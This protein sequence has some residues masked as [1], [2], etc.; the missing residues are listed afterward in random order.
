MVVSIKSDTPELNGKFILKLVDRRYAKQLRRTQRVPPWTPKIEAQYHQFILNG[1]I[2]EFL[3]RVDSADGELEDDLDDVQNE[4]FISMMARDI[5][6]N[7]VDAYKTLEDLQG[8]RVP[9]F[10]GSVKIPSSP[11]RPYAV[12]EYTDIRGLLIEYI[13][14]VPLSILVLRANKKTWQT[15]G[16]RAIKTLHQL[17]IRGVV[18]MNV[19]ARGFI[20]NPE[21]L[22]VRM[23]NFSQCRFREQYETDEEWKQVQ[24]GFA[25]ERIGRALESISHGLYKWKPSFALQRLQ[26]AFLREADEA[27]YTTED[28][29]EITKI[30]TGE[31]SEEIEDIITSMENLDLSQNLPWEICDSRKASVGSITS[32][33]SADTFYTARSWDS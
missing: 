33:S 15:I 25:E 11:D 21:N 12:S 29:T 18:S 27:S 17:R 16:K 31:T 20:V 30:E 19:R 32:D 24:T 6:D 9:Q 3:D 2:L 5:V 10:F 7:E 13:K 22:D 8:E 14:G 28:S 26:R 4:A 1:N 23:I